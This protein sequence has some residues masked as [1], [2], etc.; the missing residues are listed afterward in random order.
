MEKIPC[1]LIKDILPLYIDGAVSQETAQ[2]VETHLDECD[3]CRKEYETLREPLSLPCSPDLREEEGQLLKAMKQKL[4]WKRIAITVVSVMLTLAVVISGFLVYQEVGVVHDFFDPL[5]IAMNPVITPGQWQTVA[6]PTDAEGIHFEDTLNFD[7]I[8][9]DRKVVCDASNQNQVL[10]RV[11][12]SEGNVVVE[13]FALQP[14]EEASL[15]E[16]HR[17]TQYRVEMKA[18]EGTVLLNFH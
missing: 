12:D 9:Y 15:A 8:F 3:T 13:E 7:S 10:L 1:S 14:G 6:I 11:L 16:L 4:L 2:L 17:Y 5:R 18:E